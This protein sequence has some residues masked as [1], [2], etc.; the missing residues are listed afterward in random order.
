MITPTYLAAGQAAAV[1]PAAGVGLSLAAVGLVGGIAVAMHHKKKSPRIIG[2][3][4]FLIGIPLA[5][6][7]S[8]VLGYIAGVTLWSIPVTLILTGYVAFVFFHDG[9][10]R[11]GGGS[12]TVAVRGS[13]GGGGGG[14]HRWLQPIFGLILPALPL[15]LGGSLGNGAHS[16]LGAVNSGV[17]SAVSHTTGK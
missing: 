15:T 11:R 12:G 17:G 3:L 2:W 7:L 16:V 5:S 8:G 14:A 10:K 1:S 13:S 6:L 4:C 9:L